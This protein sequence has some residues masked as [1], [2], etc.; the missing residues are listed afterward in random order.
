MAGFQKRLNGLKDG[1]YLVW[2]GRRVV[3]YPRLAYDVPITG[4]WYQVCF[5]NGRQRVGFLGF[6]EI[7]ANIAVGWLVW[8]HSFRQLV[9]TT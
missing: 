7:E 4:W 8:K 5:S 3:N 2:Y 6:D 1:D 9:A